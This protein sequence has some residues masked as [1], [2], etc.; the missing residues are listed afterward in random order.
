MRVIA[1]LSFVVLAGAALVV[2][3]VQEPNS[4]LKMGRTIGDVYAYVPDYQTPFRVRAPASRFDVLLSPDRLPMP[5]LPLALPSQEERQLEILIAGDTG[6]NGSFQPVHASFGLRGGS[7]LSFADAT[8]DIAQ[9]IDGDIN[10]AN[11]ETVVTDRN[12]LTGSLKLF[13]F[14]THPEGVKHLLR[15][16]FNVFS[17]ANNHSM[18]YG[19]DGARETLKQ[20]GLLGVVHAG[21]GATR[22]EAGAARVL[23]INGIRVAFGAVGIGG[24]GFG[25]LMRSESRPGQ[26]VPGSDADLSDVT[27]SLRTSGADF[28]VFSAHYGTEFDVTTS[29][30]DQSRFHRV[31]SDGADMFVG[32]HQHV[33]AGVEIV[34]GK[35]LFYGLGNFLHWGTQDMSRHD[36]CHDYGLVAKVHLSAVA[37]EKPKLRAIEAIP[38]TGMHIRTR[39]MAPED[40]TVRIFAL[41]HLNNQFGQNGVQFGIEPDG[42]GLYCAPGAE[43][44]S[45]TIGARCA[46]AP[47][48]VQPAPALASRIADACSRKL[49]RMVESDGENGT[50]LTGLAA[51]GEPQ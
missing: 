15:M 10:F 12:D 25:S 27:A 5:E 47:R 51:N 35:P 36:I 49:V 3:L 13:G 24:S 1:A 2:K 42:T 38:V 50:D 28:K 26:L 19:L 46:M 14:R 37:G 6:L 33:V 48:T 43:R 22:E 45:G 29:S 32:H 30:Y 44:L 8:T 34:D 9:V 31:L 23:E 7:R 41:N 11:L 39:R 21:L 16:G 20:L 40:S 17:S 4:I 18:D